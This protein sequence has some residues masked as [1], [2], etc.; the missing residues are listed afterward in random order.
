MHVARIPLVPDAGNADLGLVHVLFG[1]AG[2]VQHGL[3]GALG[4]G[5]G[6]AGAEFVEGWHFGDW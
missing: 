1:H 3:R 4:G 5:L 2:A 6:D